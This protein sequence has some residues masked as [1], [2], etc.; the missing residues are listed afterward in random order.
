[1]MDAQINISPLAL[2]DGYFLDCDN[3]PMV[4]SNG[5]LH[6]ESSTMSKLRH[7]F[8]GRRNASSLPHCMTSTM[9]D[10]VFHRKVKVLTANSGIFH[11]FK[12]RLAE[13]GDESHT[14]EGLSIFLHNF[15]DKYVSNDDLY[16]EEENAE[17][18]Q[19]V[20]FPRLN[21][22]SSYLTEKTLSRGDSSG[23]VENIIPY[24]EPQVVMFEPAQIFDRVAKETNRD[25]S[26]TSEEA[27]AAESL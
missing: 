16:Q 21:K 7:K 19:N 17:P 14:K 24:E 5:C 11:D 4:V 25:C 26:T 1:M 20:R 18:S 9:D 2:S 12:Q 27:S 10:D 3:L 8:A 13:S 15:L 23:G 6:R 22:L